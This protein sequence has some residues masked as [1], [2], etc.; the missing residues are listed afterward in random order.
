MGKEK[1]CNYQR[2]NICTYSENGPKKEIFTV[3]EL[4]ELSL[5]LTG[6]DLKLFFSTMGTN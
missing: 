1:Y 6:D 3:K 2:E 4:D 5:K